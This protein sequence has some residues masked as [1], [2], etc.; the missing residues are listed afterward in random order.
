MATSKF[1]MTYVDQVILLVDSAVCIRDW[2]T[3]PVGGRLVSILGIEGNTVPHS[4]KVFI[5]ERV[6][7]CCS[8]FYLYKEAMARLVWGLLLVTPQSIC[9]WECSGSK[10]GMS[11]KTTNVE[12]GSPPKRCNKNNHKY[13]RRTYS[14]WLSLSLKSTN[15]NL[16]F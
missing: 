1:K 7:L 5:R 2:Q 14:P 13:G 11:L 8:N 9:Y 16:F 3:C 15:S 6:W 12:R 4:A 10:P